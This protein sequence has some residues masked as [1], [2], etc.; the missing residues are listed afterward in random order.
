[1]QTATLFPSV[2]VKLDRRQLDSCM[3]SWTGFIISNRRCRCS[4]RGRSAWCSQGCRCDEHIRPFGR[5]SRR[6]KPVRHIVRFIKMISH[7]GL[8]RC[9]T[10]LLLG[11]A[12]PALT[13]ALDSVWDIT[14]G[15]FTF[16][17]QFQH[18]R[19]VFFIEFEGD[20]DL[21]LGPV[22]GL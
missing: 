19:G 6:P 17:M 5:F 22:W 14:T 9:L 13:S 20:R 15:S 8:R 7:P 16:N 1:M 10:S 18:F 21:K 12:K 2:G 4:W 11:T 3:R